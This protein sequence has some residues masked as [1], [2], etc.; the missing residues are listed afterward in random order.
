MKC[1]ISLACQPKTA[2]TEWD[3][4]QEPFTNFVFNKAI[5]LISLGILTSPSITPI[6]S[7]MGRCVGSGVPLEMLQAVAMSGAGT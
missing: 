7:L 2:N 4:G 6:Q 3:M 1:Y 5:C